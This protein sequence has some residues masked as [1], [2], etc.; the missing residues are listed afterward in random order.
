VKA[1]D[2]ILFKPDATVVKPEGFGFGQ[3]LNGV[4][5]FEIDADAE[6]DL[7]DAKAVLTDGKEVMLSD[8]PLQD[9]HDSPPSVEWDPVVTYVK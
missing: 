6:T 4:T 2:R 1:G 5:D 9:P 8:L 7:G 3:D